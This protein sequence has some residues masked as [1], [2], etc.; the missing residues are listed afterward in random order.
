MCFLSM[1]VFHP[2]RPDFSKV[3]VYDKLVLQTVLLAV[4]C[5]LQQLMFE[6]HSV[7]MIQCSVNDMT[8]ILDYALDCA[9]ITDVNI[10]VSLFYD[11]V[12]S[13]NT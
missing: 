12:M 3:C 7:F 10:M 11:L 1:H 2:G 5:Q 13:F 6:H 9:N 8:D 4:K